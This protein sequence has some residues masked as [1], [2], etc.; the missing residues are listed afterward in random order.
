MANEPRGEGGGKR[1]GCNWSL[2]F[3]FEHSLG[4]GVGIHAHQRGRDQLGRWHELS[5]FAF[6]TLTFFQCILLFAPRCVSAP[7]VPI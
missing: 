3:P 2:G 7:E 1:G 4:G 5:V 6:L